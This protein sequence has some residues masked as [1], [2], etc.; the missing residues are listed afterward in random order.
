VG[1][2][3]WGGGWGD[4]DAGWEALSGGELEGGG[5]G[6]CLFVVVVAR[7]ELLNWERD[8]KGALKEGL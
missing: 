3:A 1:G 6:F 2:E 7:G 5:C 8:V 4:A